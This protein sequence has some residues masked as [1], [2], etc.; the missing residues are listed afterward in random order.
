MH[1]Q[2]DNPS[3]AEL[4]F[5]LTEDDL[6]DLVEGSLPAHREAVVL[7]A[8]KAKPRLGLLVKHLRADSAALVSLAEI[9]TIAPAGLAD[10]IE[11]R[12]QSEALHALADDSAH[13]PLSLPVSSVRVDE[14]GVI[15][16]LL[17]S[18]WARRFATA[19]SIAIV[20]GIAA[21]AVLQVSRSLTPAH[22]PSGIAS[23]QSGHTPAAAPPTSDA[24]AAPAHSAPLAVAAAG[25]P[26]DT[27]PSVGP[28]AP[29]PSETI[30]ASAP[31]AAPELTL[32]DAQ[33][34]A[35][36]GRLVISVIATEPGSG[37]PAVKRAESLARAI[38]REGGWHSIDMTGVPAQFTALLSPVTPPFDPSDPAHEHQPQTII[39][40]DSA[41]HTPVSPI[42]PGP[43]TLIP[44]PRPVVKAIYAV[45]VDPRERA[46]KSL[47]DSLRDTTT[48]GAP[49]PRILLR[50]V[51]QPF[52]Q[53]APLEPDA[54]LWWNSVPSRW[55]RRATIPVVVE[56]LE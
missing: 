31:P 18:V 26:A 27:A 16:I 22:S 44:P 35:R 24:S 7:A 33:R 42:R 55:V 15:R 37:F 20:G 11:A 56:T 41:L 8:L 32:A 53:T 19:A 14:P 4:P 38:G 46:I 9:D 30:A 17:E 49:A 39:A 13:A 23:T 28:P 48:T 34:L 45:E 12:L 50:A 52:A 5:G 51:D 6:V 2:P 54:I 29:G 36:E 47:I 43:S 21:F 40:S 3:P 25:N 10:G 1:D